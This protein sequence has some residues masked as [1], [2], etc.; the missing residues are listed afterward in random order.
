MVK[1]LP[2][3]QKTRVRSLD[4]EHL[5]RRKW[6]PTPG[7]LTWK[8][9]WTEEPGGL[10][11][12]GSQRVRHDLALK[13]QYGIR[14][15]YSVCHRLFPFCFPL[16]SWYFYYICVTKAYSHYISSFLLITISLTLT[17]K[18][19]PHLHPQTLWQY[20]ALQTFGCLS[21]KLTLDSAH[22]LLTVP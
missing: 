14:Q 2:A 6:Q 13:Q 20:W 3:M 21:T 11:F 8:I 1:N 5:L 22:E 15:D 9:P 18:Y 4:Q 7:F 19:I 16:F 17:E 10:Q 12:M